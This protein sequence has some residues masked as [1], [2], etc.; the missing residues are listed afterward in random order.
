VLM[1]ARSVGNADGGDIAAAGEIIKK[2]I[3]CIDNVRTSDYVADI[4]R[5][6]SHLNVRVLSCFKVNPRR[7]RHETGPITDRNAFRL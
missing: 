7:R 2:A 4:C 1:T 5:F 3:F 6:V